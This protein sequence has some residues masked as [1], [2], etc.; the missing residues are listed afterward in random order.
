MPPMT[1]EEKLAVALQEFD[2]AVAKFRACRCWSYKTFVELAT[3]RLQEA[4]DAVFD[5]RRQSV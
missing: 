3:K 5:E 1:A 4:S 2:D